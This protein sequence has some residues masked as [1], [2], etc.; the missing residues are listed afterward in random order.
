MALILVDEDDVRVA[1]LS[2]DEKAWA[3]KLDAL[4]AKMPER[5]KLVEIDDSVML[6]DRE[7]AE[8]SEGGFGVLREAGAV[9][10]DLTGGVMKISGMTH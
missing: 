6:I 1:A 2:A 5:L 8:G 4:L 3:K 7:A 10:A 9:L